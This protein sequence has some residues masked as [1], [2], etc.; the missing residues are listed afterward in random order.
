[1]KKKI[2]FVFGLTV[3]LRIISLLWLKEDPLFYLGPRNLNGRGLLTAPVWLDFIIPLI[4]ILILY[5]KPENFKFNYKKLKNP[6]LTSVLV[7]STPVIIGL[8]LNNYVQKTL[9][10]FEINQTLFLRYILFVLTFLSLNIFTD[11]ILISGIKKRIRILIIII[12]LAAAPYTQDLFS[13]T[14]S[15]YILLGLINSVGVSTVIFY[16]A[17]RKIYKKNPVET[18]AAVSF[19]GIFL[20]FSI[21]NIL[22]VSFFTIFLPFITLFFIAFILYKDSK[23]LKKIIIGSIPFL[24]ALFLNYG[25]PKLV[26]PELANE[27]IEKRNDNSFFTEK[28]GN[29][30]VKYKEKKLKNI[31]I[32]FAKVIDAAN[33]ICRKKFGFSPEVKELIINGIAPGGFHAEF[34]N[35]IVGNIIN[36]TYIKNCNDSSFL[37]N[38]ELSANFPDPVNAILHEYSHLFGVIPYYK[39]WPGAEE[40][41]WATFSA[42]RI[43]KLLSKNYKKAEIWQ[44]AYNYTEQANKITKQNLSGKAVVWSHPNEYGGFILWYNLEKIYGLKELYRKR[45]QNTEHN[46]KGSLFILSNP[47]KAKKIVNVFGKNNFI[48]FGKLPEKKI[49]DI[50]TLKDYLYLAETT[51]INKKRIKKMYH[52]MKNKKINPEIPIP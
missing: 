28:V 22:S 38:P 3:I 35:K 32:K 17:L 24:T 27:L 30:T 42:T 19:A 33:Q 11:S 51:G 13:T 7:L 29:I 6:L 20:I 12:F 44:P 46:I 47:E 21:Y 39:W 5:K 40:E 31:S 4:T 16:I 1:M 26:S 25:L 36:E 10:T 18:S 23:L 2:Y 15:M 34:P 43:A 41:G 45:T 52:F 9:F 49:G 50:Y 8:L 14:N 48:K 37:N